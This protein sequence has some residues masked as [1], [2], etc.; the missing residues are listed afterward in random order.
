MQKRLCVDG[1]LLRVGCRHLRQ[2]DPVMDR[3][4]EKHGPCTIGQGPFEPFHTIAVSIIGQQLSAKA[5][6]TIE[7]RIAELV[8]SPFQANDFREVDAKRLRE[9]GLSSRKA[10]TLRELGERVIDGR[11]RFKALATQED[12]AVSDALM[13]VPG[14]GPWTAEMFLIFGLR[15][16]DVLSLSDA[17]L[18]R[19]VI[20]LYGE[21]NE[22]AVVGRQWR[23]YAS[24]AS[25]YLWRDLDS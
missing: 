11:L 9:A 25:W 4:I 24:I 15:R 17:G 20:K 22:L 6:D 7:R 3:L 5:A 12:E 10:A 1:A 14:I 2:A 23:P 19:A 13:D 18:Q 16:P 8:P 21:R